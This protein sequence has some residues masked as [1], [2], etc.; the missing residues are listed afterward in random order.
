[1]SIRFGLKTGCDS[2]YGSVVGTQ[3]VSWSVGMCGRV[4]DMRKMTVMVVANGMCG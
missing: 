2:I 3:N 1:M 4:V